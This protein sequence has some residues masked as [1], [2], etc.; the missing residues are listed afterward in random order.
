MDGFDYQPDYMTESGSGLARLVGARVLG[1]K[2]DDFTVIL[3]TDRGW[4]YLY[5]EQDC[6]EDVRVE[7]IT[8]DLRDLIGEV[9][10]VAE[11]RCNA[12]NEGQKPNDWSESWTWTFYT[13]QTMHSDVTIRWVGESNGYYSEHVSAAFLTDEQLAE[14][15]GA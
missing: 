9:V 1:V 12:N 3:R 7:D 13:I 5:H 14:I 4:F 11:E 6:C 10:T 2:H 15:V 8:G